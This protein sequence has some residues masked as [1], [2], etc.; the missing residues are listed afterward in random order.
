MWCR[1][2]NASI[3]RTMFEFEY[4]PWLLALVAIALI[5]ACWIRWLRAQR[6]L[7]VL[8]QLVEAAG[9]PMLIYDERGKLIYRSEGLI[10]FDSG[11]L[12]ALKRRRDLPLPGQEQ[13]GELVIDGNLYRY[14]GNL[15]EFKPG[16]KVAVYFL[17]YQSSGK[18]DAAPPK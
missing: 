18:S 1:R 15:L 2:R 17:E 16:H 5:V 4:Y 12:A 10:V 13:K 9:R 14:H 7:L 8:K 6:L 3:I 11:S